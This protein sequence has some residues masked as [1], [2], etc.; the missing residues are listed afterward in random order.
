M[1]EPL[2]T[3]TWHDQAPAIADAARTLLRLNAADPDVPRLAGCA[4]A[5][6]SAIDHWTNLCEH[7]DR[8]SM[9]VGGQTWWTWADG[10]APPD[11]VTAAEQLCAELF[12]RKDAPFGVLNASSANA[13]P[14]YVSRDQLAGV[15]T[16]I[17]PYREGWGFA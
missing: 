9:T 3:G 2:P 11:A 7:A 15:L 10:D 4:R 5:A 16:L 13:V 8:L 17:A 6:C 14:M 1:S 12:R